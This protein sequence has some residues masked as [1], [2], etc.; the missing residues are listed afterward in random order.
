MPICFLLVTYNINIPT[1]HSLCQTLYY[2]PAFFLRILLILCSLVNFHTLMKIVNDLFNRRADDSDVPTTLAWYGWDLKSVIIISESNIFHQR[3]KNYV[4][5]EL[6]K[7]LES[8]PYDWNLDL[9]FLSTQIVQTMGN[10]SLLKLKPSSL[11]FKTDRNSIRILYE[12]DWNCMRSDY[13][14]VSCDYLARH[15][16]I[17]QKY[18]T[19][20]YV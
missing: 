19:L 5:T 20:Q 14:H 1:H 18:I 10:A 11:V 13:F 3:S 9:D 4:K 12:H 17:I 15:I 7:T 8:C 2:T 16:K 6:D